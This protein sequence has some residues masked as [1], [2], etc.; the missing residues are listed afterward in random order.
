MLYFNLPIKRAV[1]ISQLV[2]LLPHT[3]SPCV[4][5]ARKSS[6]PHEQTITQSHAH[7]QCTH[8]LHTHHH[9]RT[10]AYFIT[11][12][13]GIFGLMFFQFFRVDYTYPEAF[14]RLLQRRQRYMYDQTEDFDYP[15]WKD[16]TQQIERKRLQIQMLQVPR[17]GD[18]VASWDPDAQI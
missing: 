13:T 7:T 12:Y 1:K 16:L 3:F 17:I 9:T 11:F 4:P 6:T 10:Q 14:A 15:Q 8:T 5:P 18:G 2:P